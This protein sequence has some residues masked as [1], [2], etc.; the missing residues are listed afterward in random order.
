[1]KRLIA[2]LFA[3]LIASHTIAATLTVHEVMGLRP[4]MAKAA[5]HEALKGKGEMEREERKRQEIWKLQD[6]R[7]SALMLGFDEKLNLRYV[8]AVAKPAGKKVRF[9]EVINVKKA[10]L[11]KNGVNHQYTL[12]V[13]GDDSHPPFQV[14][15]R[16]KDSKN[17]TYLSL[18]AVEK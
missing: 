14:I 6:E 5:V 3:F 18:K 12:T 7:Y 4:G 11:R 1:M 15:A 17:I 10:K 8:T 16:G 9:S 2:I 13:E